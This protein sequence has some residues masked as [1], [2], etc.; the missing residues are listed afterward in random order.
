MAIQ[1]IY[2][3]QGKEEVFNSK[4][5][6]VTIG[7]QSG[8]VD[9]DLNLTFDPKVSRLH[10]R[11]RLEKDG[12][13]IEDLNSKN[14]TQVNS[15][16]IKGKGRQSLQA[17]DTIR[18]GETTLWVRI[19]EKQVEAHLTKRSKKQII[20]SGKQKVES[21]ASSKEVVSSSKEATNPNIKVLDAHESAL[22][23]A[24]APGIKIV[25][26][27]DA[28]V[29]VLTP[30]E[31]PLTDAKRLALLY[32]LPLKFG[33]E[34][35]LD[36]LLQT[37]VE[38]LIE[39]I[40]NAV[41]GALL[42]RD[43]ESDELLLK[44]YFSP[45]EP[46]VS[47]TLARRAM[48]EGKGFIWQRS[49]ESDISR[50]ILELQI[51]TGMYAPLLWQGKALGVVCVDNPRHNS[52]FTNSDLRLMLAVA[53]HAAIAVANHQLQEDLR[54]E[55]K[56]LERLLVS[57]SPKVRKK[58]LERVRYGRLRPGGKRSEVTIL[59]A[60]IRGF[61]KLSA[62]MDAE[63]ILDV[64]NDYFSVL[65][66]PISKYDGTVDK[67]VG[68]AIL[69]VFGS[70]EPDIQQHKKAIR[71]AW[72]MQEMI[73]ELNITRASRDQVTC[74]FGI[75]V[76]CGEVLH[77]FIGTSDQ[78]EFTVI[79]DVV[80]RA[81]R[82]CDSAGAGKVLISP[83]LYQRVWQ[84]VQAEKITIKTKHEGNLTAYQITGLKI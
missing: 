84:T 3:Y 19:F 35:Q 4:E 66:N 33:A 5:V 55:A 17:G 70:P 29:P 49:K 41:R 80:N 23:P 44:T 48:T 22:I 72:E 83:E 60:D 20:Q 59:Y 37:I 2:S 8:D 45:D 10:A 58:L 68:D 82:Y 73:K 52:S 43:R 61:T 69:A 79:G 16:E 21:H 39:V 75:G 76:H 26:A 40:P 9:V 53:Q 15:K 78:I 14:G 74:E 62:G 64:L 12:C 1:I 50:S 36:M 56:L 71:A 57:F 13:W 63:D 38:R 31:A 34:T 42:L 30:A 11:I 32:E 25:E 65:V 24:Q 51:E 6:E 28:N 27:L 77:G 47:K 54:Q 81:S 7:R 67:F 46:A 18:I